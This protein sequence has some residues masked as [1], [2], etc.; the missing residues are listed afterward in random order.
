MGQTSS[1]HWAPITIV[2]MSILQNSRQLWAVDVTG[3]LAYQLSVSEVA[4]QIKMSLGGAFCWPN[5]GQNFNIDPSTGSILSNVLA[6]DSCLYYLLSE[7][8]IEGSYDVVKN[9]RTGYTN[10]LVSD[11]TD[12]Y[13]LVIEPF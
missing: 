2:A 12:L 9:S 5:A 4:S 7:A 10:I 13:W 1:P 8:Y 3:E 6:R 11:R